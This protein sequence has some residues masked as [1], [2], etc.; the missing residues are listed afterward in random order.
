MTELLE[1]LLRIVFSI[2][3]AATAVGVVLL[4]VHSIWGIWND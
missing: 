2:W 3:M 1:L 4:S